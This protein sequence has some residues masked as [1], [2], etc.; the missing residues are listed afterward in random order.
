MVFHL[1]SWPLSG[2]IHTCTHYQKTPIFQ[3]VPLSITKNKYWPFPSVLC[4]HIMH[5]TGKGPTVTTVVCT[6]RNNLVFW[7]ALEWVL[8]CWVG[9]LLCH[10]TMNNEQW[11]MNGCHMQRKLSL[12]HLYCGC[13]MVHHLDVCL[14]SCVCVCMYTCTCVHLCMTVSV[15]V[16]VC[17]CV[18]VQVLVCMEFTSWQ[19]AG[20]LTCSLGWWGRPSVLVLLC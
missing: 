19:S 12:L 7:R 3:Y 13:I 4:T 9:F 16:C 11:T 15:C 17:V 14:I 8:E 2:H 10:F 18:C 1:H 6:F 20:L 5:W